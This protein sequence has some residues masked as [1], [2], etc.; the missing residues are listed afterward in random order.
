MSV[1]LILL[2]EQIKE[3]VE[4][5]LDH[6]DSVGMFGGADHL[7]Q[8]LLQLLHSYDDFIFGHHNGASDSPVDQ[9]YKSLKQ[10][11][12]AAAHG[13][14]GSNAYSNGVDKSIGLVGRNLIMM[15]QKL[16]KMLDLWTQF[17]RRVKGMPLSQQNRAMQPREVRPI[18]PS[19]A[20]TQ[21][22]AGN[23]SS[24]EGIA[25]VGD[26]SEA[27]YFG[28]QLPPINSK[29]DLSRDLA[30]TMQIVKQHFYMQTF[31]DLRDEMSQAYKTLDPA[32][33]ETARQG[34]AL[35]VWTVNDFARLIGDYQKAI[36]QLEV[37]M[38]PPVVRQQLDQPGQQGQQ[39]ISPA[40]IRSATTPRAIKPGA[41]MPPSDDE[42][43]GLG[44]SSQ[45]QTRN[46]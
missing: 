11:S 6:D 8:E 5:H 29:D 13:N 21:D 46:Y 12:I 32:D 35:A 14:F 20:S 9:I 17:A 33:F 41:V 16:R 2:L 18:P 31:S 44:Q 42:P 36:K 28:G 7:R 39:R 10:A 22:S 4:V 37:S 38:P 3:L 1:N 30:N 40:T 25:R 23:S 15:E 26:L 19:E 27:H 34:L 43:I 24:E 45:Q